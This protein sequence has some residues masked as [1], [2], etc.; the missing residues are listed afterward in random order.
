LR[1]NGGFTLI[2]IMIVVLI[3]AIL[4]GVALPNFLHAREVGRARACQSTLRHIAS[5][6]EQWAMDNRAGP[7]STPTAVDL[8]D[9]YI[10]SVPQDVLPE[11]PLAGSYTIGNLATQPTCS[12]GA[13]VDPG[14]WDDHIIQW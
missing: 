11:C 8:V 14:S 12:I 2:E 10:K 7:S 3:I 13:N 6:K 4:I 5:A 9:E 1:K